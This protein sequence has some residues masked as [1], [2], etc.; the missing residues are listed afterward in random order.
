VNEPD[1]PPGTIDVGIALTVRDLDRSLAF[2]CDYLG[3]DPLG[4]EDD[5]ADDRRMATVRYGNA[6]IELVTGEPGP[7]HQ[8]Y[9]IFW[10]VEKI[11]D[12]VER[13][14]AGG[15]SLVRQME[16]GVFCADPDGNTILIRQAEPDDQD[17][18]W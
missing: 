5:T 8:N 9:R 16:Y 3:F 6:L 12:A 2:Y 10:T 4:D 15:G 17:T 13:I 11:K 1:S 14:L 7:R 18:F